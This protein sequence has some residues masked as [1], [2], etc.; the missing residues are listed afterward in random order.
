MSLSRHVV[1]RRLAHCGQ[2]RWNSKERALQAERFAD[3]SRVLDGWQ[4]WASEEASG[5]SP[6][7][8]QAS[9]LEVGHGSASDG[10]LTGRKVGI[11]EAGGSLR[12]EEASRSKS[13]ADRLWGDE[14]SDCTVGEKDELVV[15]SVVSSSPTPVRS[16]ISSAA[17]RDWARKSCKRCGKMG[18]WVGECKAPVGTIRK[19][20]KEVV[21]LKNDV[22]EELDAKLLV[23]SNGGL[24][25]VGSVIEKNKNVVEDMDWQ[26]VENKKAGRM[27]LPQLDMVCST[28]QRFVVLSDKENEV[29]VCSE[30]QLE[31]VLPSCNDDRGMEYKRAE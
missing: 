14:A 24:A 18:H 4:A 9:S 30:D 6:V 26:A 12:D 20:W 2:W 21:P 16:R 22:R 27:T 8:G 1:V 7:V 19:E 28:S 5:G 15:K 17:R 3:D 25:P 31:S 29:G 10:E 13:G 11:D 23:K